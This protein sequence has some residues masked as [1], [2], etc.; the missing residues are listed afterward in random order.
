MPGTDIFEGLKQCVSVPCPLDTIQ[1]LLILINQQSLG[2]LLRFKSILSNIMAEFL[3]YSYMEYNIASSYE[4]FVKYAKILSFISN[5]LSAEIRINDLALMMNCPYYTLSRNFKAD[6]G[7]G[8]KEYI[9]RMILKKA[10]QLL[11]TTDMNIC[12]LSQQL[13]FTDQYYFSRFFKRYEKMS[14]SEY[15]RRHLKL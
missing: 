6:M 2:S 11:L 10:K 8:L 13:H 9:E 1:Q 5:S 12:E 7:I 4:V 3:D 14:P 15:K